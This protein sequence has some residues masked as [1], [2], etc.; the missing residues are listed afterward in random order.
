MIKRKPEV[1]IDLAA[2]QTENIEIEITNATHLPN[3]AGCGLGFADE[4]P[5]GEDLPI[6]D[7]FVVCGEVKGYTDATFEYPLTMHPDAQIDGKVYEVYL[8]FRTR[9]GKPFG[10]IIPIK[11]RCNNETVVYRDP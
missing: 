3:K 8:T 1:L 4:Q 7:N 10:E 11:V 6:K 5:C 2:G 9:T